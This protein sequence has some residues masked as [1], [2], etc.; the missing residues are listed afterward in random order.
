MITGI[1]SGLILMLNIYRV[2]KENEI[3]QRALAMGEKLLRELETS[4]EPLYTGLAHGACGPAWAL[5]QLGGISKDE[6]FIKKSLEL[7]EY[8]NTYF[9]EE[10]SN[11]RDIRECVD[12]ED[13]AYWCFGAAGIGIARIML[14]QYIH[15]DTVKKDVRSVTGR[16]RKKDIIRNHSLCHGIFGK[17]DVMLWMVRNG[18]LEE[19]V[20]KNECK[21]AFESICAEG[22]I[23]GSK[24][25]LADYSFMNGVSGVGYVL[26]RMLNP[27]L[28]CILAIEV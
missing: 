4:E 27:S 5:A 22:F 10:L 12:E 17:I 8:E 23:S 21:E 16:L 1:S 24:G 26:L 15:G 7:V 2:L 9:D 13:I 3:Y 19:S 25:N 20:L 28:P 18:Y 14:N 6:R 11:W